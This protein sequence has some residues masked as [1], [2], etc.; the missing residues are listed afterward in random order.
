[1][2]EIELARIAGGTVTLHDARR[3]L[4]WSVDLEPFEI[5]VF[6]VTE[7]QLA[8]LLD[9]PSVHPRR[10]AVEVSWLRAIRFCNA[11]SEWE[12]L[13]P[14]YGFDGEDVTWHVD[15]DGYRLPTEAEWELACRAGS[16]GATYGP[17]HE[18]AWTSADGVSSPQNVGAKLPN[19]NGLFDILG[20]VWEWCWD[21]LDPARYDSYR[22][23]RGGGFAD[24]AFSVRAGTRRGGAPRMSHE[25]V[26]FRLA[27]G[28]MDG[29]DAAQG[30]SAAVDRE[31]ASIDGPLPSGWTPRR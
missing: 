31:R 25:D 21:L 7:E 12:G 8:E 28:A 18:V 1:M 22:V 9:V 20:N 26:G 14:A 6:P 13:D 3:M 27:R 24:D 4:R 16:T 23:F 10:P 30:W 11:A 17:L 2:D 5:G 19:L 29:Q 15:A